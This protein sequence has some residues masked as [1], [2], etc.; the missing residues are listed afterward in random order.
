[1]RL[2]LLFVTLLSWSPA[3]TAQSAEP[4]ALDVNGEGVAVARAALTLPGSPDSLRHLLTDAW[5]WPRLFASPVRVRSVT[6]YDDRTVTDMYLSPPLFLSEL[7]MV[8]ETREV[9]RAR[10][11]TT[12]L[13]GDVRRYSHVW[14]LTP[15]AGGR[16]T[17]AVLELTMQ[18]RTWMPRWL[19]RWLIRQELDG[20]LEH[21]LA[22]AARRG[23]N[24]TDCAPGEPAGSPSG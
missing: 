20:H 22:E 12:L 5:N 4:V 23:D 15:L 14:L 17:R 1:M 6:R 19:L 24:A 3:G 9:S 10:I 16:C 11:E 8:V 2:T 13:R 21:V 18:L 7:H